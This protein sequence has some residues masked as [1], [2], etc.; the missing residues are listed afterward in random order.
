MY[1]LAT[2]ERRRAAPILSVFDKM[3]ELLAITDTTLRDKIIM[4]YISPPEP[5]D[6]YRCSPLECHYNWTRQVVSKIGAGYV[7]L[8]I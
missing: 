4:N 7:I 6:R 3:P 2:G 1:T 5:L 8:E